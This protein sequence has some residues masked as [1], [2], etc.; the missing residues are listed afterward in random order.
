MKSKLSFLKNRNE[1]S[2]KRKWPAGAAAGGW[3]LTTNGHES[4]RIFASEARWFGGSVAEAGGDA[5]APAQRTET[6]RAV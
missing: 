6:F 3:A 1:E 4:T 5:G 2:R